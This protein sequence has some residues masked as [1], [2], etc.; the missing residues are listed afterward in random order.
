MMALD[1]G[2]GFGKK[3]NRDYF[4]NAMSLFWENYLLK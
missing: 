1:E 2:H 4:N 3:V